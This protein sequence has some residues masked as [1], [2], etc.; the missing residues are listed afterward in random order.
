VFVL[1]VVG[2]DA[3]TKIVCQGKTLRIGKK[4]TIV[5][6]SKECKACKNYILN[7]D[8][9]D[10]VRPAYPDEARTHRISG[11]VSVQITVNEQGEVE[12]NIT[13]VGPPLFQPIAIEAVRKTRFKRLIL[14]CKPA[15][16]AGIFII[17]F[18][19]S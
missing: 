9:I 17:N 14:D 12:S 18:R 16:Y 2:I 3:Q 7:D 15:K 19:P 10:F 8:A 4:T 5:R 13:A 1:A 11:S 6:S